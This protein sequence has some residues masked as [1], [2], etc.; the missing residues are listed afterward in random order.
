MGLHVGVVMGSGRENSDMGEW[1]W[2]VGGSVG[3][4]VLVVMGSG[5]ECG[6]MFAVVVMGSGRE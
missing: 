6:A 1:R 2:G 5:R 3:L 4:Y